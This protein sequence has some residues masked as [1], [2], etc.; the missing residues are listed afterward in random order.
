MLCLDSLGLNLVFAPRIGGAGTV[1][2]DHIASG[3][4]QRRERGRRRRTSNEKQ[5]LVPFIWFPG[6]KRTGEQS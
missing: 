2:V 6:I 1:E 3:L 5:R 4:E